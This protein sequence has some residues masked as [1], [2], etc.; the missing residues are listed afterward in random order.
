MKFSIIFKQSL[1][2]FRFVDVEADNF[3]A[4]VVENQAK[5]FGMDTPL[6]Y[7]VIDWDAQKV[8][9]AS[10]AGDGRVFE[11]PDGDFGELTPAEY[12]EEQSA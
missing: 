1:Q 6:V 2:R 10:M 8:V 9:P 12:F 4:L 3:D 5:T 7:G 11:V